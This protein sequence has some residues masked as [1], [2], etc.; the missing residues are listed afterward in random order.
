MQLNTQQILEKIKARAQ[1]LGFCLCGVT[2]ATDLT[3][4][5]R[6]VGWLERGDYGCM[7]YLNSEYH[8]EKRRNPRNVAPWARSIVVLAWPYM[9]NRST[10]AEPCGQIAGYVGDEDYHISLPR[11]LKPL[12]DELP[13]ILGGEVRA[14]IFTDSA[15]IPERELAVDAGLGWIGRNSCLIH[16][17]FGSSFLLVEIFLDQEINLSTPQIN[18]HCGTC[19]RCVDACPTGCIRPD[20]TIDARQCISTWTIEDKGVFSEQQQALIGNRLFG[21]DICQSVCPWNKSEMKVTP[22]PGGQMSVDEMVDLLS[23]TE[24][25]FKSRFKT[26]ALGRAK[27]FGLIRNFSAVLGNLNEKGATKSLEGL[28]A[29][30]SDPLIQSVIGSAL[31]RIH[32]RH[33]CN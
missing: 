33:N 9:L 19:H 25:E 24:T 4:Y 10:G 6:Y 5:H 22:Y 15:P 32:G 13:L 31:Q 11:F 29:T 3:E 12:M 2:R 18:D 23:I 7:D 27:R 1:S 8:R 16:P 14:Q 21:C 26:S 20:R 28:F 17:E 30:E